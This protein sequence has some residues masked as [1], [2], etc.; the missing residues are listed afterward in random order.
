[1]EETPS[2]DNCHENDPAAGGWATLTVAAWAV[3][4]SSA[5][6]GPPK[7]EPKPSYDYTFA[8]GIVLL[9]I[10]LG[11]LCV[12]RPSGRRREAGPQQYVAKNV[13]VDD[14]K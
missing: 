10:I 14:E 4:I 12:L 8:Y 1:M 9:G 6:C 13:P 7:A 3:T 11:L 2:R 5:T